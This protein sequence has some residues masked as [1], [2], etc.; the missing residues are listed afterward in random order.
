MDREQTTSGPLPPDNLSKFPTLQRAREAYMDLFTSDNSLSEMSYNTRQIQLTKPILQLITGPG[1][2]RKTDCGHILEFYSP[3][4]DWAEIS[5]F[6]QKKDIVGFHLAAGKS[7]KFDLN[8]FLGKGEYPVFREMDGMVADIYLLE[9]D[10]IDV[11]NIQKLVQFLY[12][13]QRKFTDSTPLPDSILTRAGRKIGLNPTYEATWIDDR[14]TKLAVRI[15]NPGEEPEEFAWKILS[16]H[17]SG[18]TVVG[19]MADSSNTT[20]EL[21]QKALEKEQKAFIGELA[22]DPVKN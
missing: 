3:S 2:I 10:K 12:P 7:S 21:V 22:W 14:Q 4:H 9:P 11:K 6:Q 16:T 17:P 15:K 13:P 8:S 5:Q 18:L 1:N 19:R 20:T